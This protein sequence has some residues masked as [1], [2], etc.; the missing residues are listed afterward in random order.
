MMLDLQKKR[1]LIH[2]VSTHWNSSCEMIERYLEQEAAIYSAL[3][4]RSTK[5]KDSSNLTDQE[6]S[7][8]REFD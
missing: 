7:V 4:D 3:S 5:N 6:V 2:D 1:C 8:W